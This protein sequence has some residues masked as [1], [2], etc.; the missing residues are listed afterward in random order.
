M[1]AASMKVASWISGMAVAAVAIAAAAISGCA[2]FWDPLPS[3]GGGTNPASGVFYVINAK[4]LQI[5]GFSFAAGASSPT[6]VSGSP[7]AVS[8]VPLAMAI[9]PSGSFLYVSTT[10]NGIAPYTVNS[11]GSLS[12]NNQAITGDPAISMQVDPSGSWLLEGFPGVT[13]TNA[14]LSAI[15]INSS[16]G[17]VDSTRSIQTVR[18]PAN[19]F[20]EIAV[21]PSGSTYPYVFVAMGSGGTAVIPFNSG[22]TTPL[23]SIATFGVK[24]TAGTDNTIAVDPQNRVLYV[25]ETAAASGTQTGGLRVLTIGSSG[26]TEI[27]TGT[28]DAA[29]KAYPYTTGGTGP[30]SIVAANSYVYVANIA[31]SGS[32]NGNISG[33]SLNV[34]GSTYTLSA[35]NT[36]TTGLLTY[37]LAEDSTGSYLLAVNY[38]GS[39]DLNTFTFDSTTTGQ[40][41]A[42]PTAATGTDPSGATAIV[43][44]P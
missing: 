14:I 38:N 28:T 3:G 41:D 44:A 10:G 36:V 23:G 11:D 27:T 18:L 42:G 25:G 13:G 15:P 16:T 17:L 22:N 24:N 39:P 34:S 35:V 32:S 8:T 7:Y 19:T 43:A 26:V 2:G 30:R 31:V 29:G 5:A 33:F 21:S 37:G 20:K 40:L 6:A 4:T 12:G 9:T 1:K